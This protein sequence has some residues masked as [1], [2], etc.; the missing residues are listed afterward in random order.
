MVGTR[1]IDFMKKA[2]ADRPL[3]RGSEVQATRVR[4]G[5]AGHNVSLDGTTG[6]ASTS[7]TVSTKLQ[8]IA[9][10]SGLPVIRFDRARGQQSYASESGRGSDYRGTG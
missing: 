6:E 1:L 9:K 5:E 10:Q 3:P 8:R 4:E 7:P 2:T